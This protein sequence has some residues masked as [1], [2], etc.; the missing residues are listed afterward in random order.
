MRVEHRAM[1]SLY[2]SAEKK[3]EVLSKTEILAKRLL[4]DL[5]Q[6]P[7]DAALNFRNQLSNI[8]TCVT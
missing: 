8:I 2:A 7:S 4:R 5:R 3:T 6:S 1:D